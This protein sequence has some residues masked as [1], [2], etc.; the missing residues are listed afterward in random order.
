MGRFQLSSYEN[1][2]VLVTGHTGF[3]GG[4]LCHA[5]AMAGA[6]V[7]GFSLP[8]ESHFF[9]WEFGENVTSYFGDVGIFSE[10]FQVFQKE[11]PEYV[12]HLAAQPIVL[13]SY[14]DPV[15]TYQTNVMGTVHL[16]QCVNLTP[17]VVSFVNVT[18][19]K[20]YE[21]H[22]WTWGYRETDHLDG[23]DPYSNSKSCSELVT[24]S[25]IRSF[26]QEKSIPTSTLRAGNVIGGGDRAE[27]RIIPD[28]VR[29]AIEG[30]PIFL[31]NPHSVRPYQ[32]VLEPVYAYLMVGMAQSEDKNLASSYNIGPGVE[33][34]ITTETMVQHFTRCWGGLCQL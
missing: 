33:D 3:K 5:L 16:C 1:K 10:I 26:L 32:H 22:E 13:R 17:S 20:V 28:C 11:Q 8:K 12:F 18:T 34:C 30:K 23:Y 4:W 27:N 25:F 6:K 24:A 19:D 7:V 29:A 2:K 9:P 21:N 31:R 15:E 14:E